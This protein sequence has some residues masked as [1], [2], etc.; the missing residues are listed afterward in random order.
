MQSGIH[1]Q[2]SEVGILRQRLAP[3][4]LLLSLFVNVAC[5]D[6][7]LPSEVG[8][9]SAEQ[10]NPL[11][12]DRG[13]LDFSQNPLL[14]QRILSS[15]HGYF[16]FINI[17]FSQEVCRA[18]AEVLAPYPDFNLH[19]DA[20]LEQYAVTD[21]GRGL[22]DFDDSTLGPSLI[23]LT[24]FSVSLRLAAQANGWESR[25]DEFFDSFLDGYQDA[26]SDPQTVASEPGVVARLREDFSYDRD[27]YFEWIGEIA[28]PIPNS[29]Q[30]ALLSALE[31]YIEDVRARRP[32]LGPNYFDVVRVGSLKL[33]I[34][35]AMDRKYL[36][37][38]RGE[39]AEIADDVVLELKT[40]RNLTGIDCVSTGQTDDPYRILMGQSIAYQPYR[41]LGYV[42]FDGSTFWIH[43]WVDNYRELSVV[44][45][46]ETPEELIEVARDVG[47]QLG[48]GHPNQL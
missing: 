21:L 4:V 11:L 43:A 2:P 33:G 44:G 14:L 7:G 32:N 41:L 47:V 20:H 35:S 42:R 13:S 24:R 1:H 34:G 31:V 25:A 15:P 8:S 36:I 9:D 12:V 27:R 38:I 5:H 40:V 28:T 39:T 48:R 45:D 30:Q 22:T 37:Q 10:E 17:L 19:G 46:L 26:L 29:E 3:T 18:F 23:D 6:S 16:R